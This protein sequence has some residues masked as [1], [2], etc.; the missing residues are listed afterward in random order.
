MKQTF[1]LTDARDRLLDAAERLFAE[2]GLAT[3]VREITAAAKANIAAVNYHFGS[4]D[5]LL[6]AVFHR[7]VGA[8]NAKRLE[9]LTRYEAESS[10]VPVDKILHAFVQPMA[11]TV[12]EA[13]HVPRLAGRVFVEAE[14]HLKR[15][16]LTG[17]Q[18]L[19]ARFHGA[20]RRAVPAVPPEELWWRLIFL[21]GS[22][23]FTGTNYH[24]FAAV[25][26]GAIG[27][28]TIPQTTERLIRFGA[29]GLS[30][31]LPAK[32]RVRHV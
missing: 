11:D 8:V 19:M 5:N 6:L 7:R 18:E 2:K 23:L 14:P 13:P 30:A 27:H 17:F 25:T 12:A 16:M 3:P 4:K 20:L 22:M 21:V 9:L 28:D 10:P 1:E 26:G 31:P 29:A 24:E 15:Q 32:R